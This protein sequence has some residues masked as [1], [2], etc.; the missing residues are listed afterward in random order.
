MR[1]MSRARNKKHISGA[2][3]IAHPTHLNL[4]HRGQEMGFYIR[5][6]LLPTQLAKLTMC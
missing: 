1:G 2:T 3:K 5:R 4:F 6:V